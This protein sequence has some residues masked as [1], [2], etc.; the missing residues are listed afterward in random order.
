MRAW[1]TEGDFRKAVELDQQILSYLS[2]E[3][4][5]EAFSTARHL[6]YVERI[7]AKVFL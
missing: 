7:F 5:G 4:I 3:R 2:P 1:E 6:V